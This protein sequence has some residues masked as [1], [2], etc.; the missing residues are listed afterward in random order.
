MTIH[1]GPWQIAYFVNMFIKFIIMMIS[2]YNNTDHKFPYR[3]VGSIIDTV[4][5]TFVLWMG[6]FFV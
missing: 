3:T 2:D 5:M 6:G 1:L 4:V